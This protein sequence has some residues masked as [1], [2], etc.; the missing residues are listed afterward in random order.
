[1]QNRSVVHQAFWTWPAAREAKAAVDR[2]EN[3]EEFERAALPHLNDLLRTA[4]HL[5][6]DRSRAE[7]AVQE[8]CV[9]ALRSMDRFTHGTNMRAWLFGILFNVVRHQRRKSFRFRL[10]G[11]SEDDRQDQIAAAPVL[12]DRLTDGSILSALDRIPQ[13][14]RE[15]VLLVDVEEFSYK[16]AAEIIGVPVGTVMSRLSRGRAALRTELAD[17][18][19]AWGIGTRAMEGGRS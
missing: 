5:S 15:V 2:R 13:N 19:K 4:I 11:D 17:I 16:E 1:M 12:P 18:A 6:G 3:V 8:T 14:F 10:F 7:D 9:Q